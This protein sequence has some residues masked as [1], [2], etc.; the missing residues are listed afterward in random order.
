MLGSSLDYERNLEDVPRLAVRRIADVYIV[1][2]LEDADLKRLAVEHADPARVPHAR[3]LRQS[4]PPV[5]G[6]L[7]SGCPGARLRDQG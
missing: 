3:E 5:E 1:D 6:V 7:T 2:L 4:M